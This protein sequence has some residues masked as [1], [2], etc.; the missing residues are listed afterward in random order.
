MV[1]RC[2]PR[3]RRCSSVVRKSAIFVVTKDEV[4]RT[5]TKSAHRRL[6]SSVQP[7]GAEHSEPP[8]K[9][10]RLRSLEPLCQPRMQVPT[11]KQ[12]A[13]ASTSEG[14]VG[15][16]AA[17]RGSSR[18][19]LGPP[20]SGCVYSRMVP[21]YPGTSA[22]LTKP[23]TGGTTT[24]TACC[25]SRTSSTTPPNTPP[26]KPRRSNSASTR[27]TVAGAQSNAVDVGR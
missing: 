11:Q 24:H 20:Y 22:E 3:L 5:T 26:S 21:L 7:A 6:W 18:P 16:S 25:P 10:N 19:D 23:T 12:K 13:P 8:L 27:I 9:R 1:V 14:L 4:F 15:P 2:S 17:G